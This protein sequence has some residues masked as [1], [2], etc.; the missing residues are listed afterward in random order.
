MNDESTN[1]IYCGGWADFLGYTDSL[2]TFMRKYHNILTRMFGVLFGL[3]IILSGI[4]SYQGDRAGYRNIYNEL[5]VS[6][7][8]IFVGVFIIVVSLTPIWL[9]K[10]LRSL[11]KSTTTEKKRTTKID[12]RKKA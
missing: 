1:N 2:M 10:K 12:R 4:R 9:V 8:A 3:S 5:I 7:W 6:E 11:D